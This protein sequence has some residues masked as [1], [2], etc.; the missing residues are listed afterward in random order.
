MILYK[1]LNRE[2]I[3]QS[4]YV[5]KARGELSDYIYLLF[6]DACYASSIWLFSNLA[7]P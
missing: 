4:K 1:K 5:G 6:T 7:T 3:D 2:A